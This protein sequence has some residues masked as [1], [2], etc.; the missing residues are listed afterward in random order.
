MSRII[1]DTLVNSIVFNQTF[2]TDIMFKTFNFSEDSSI[3]S[4][5]IFAMKLMINI[6][7]GLDAYSWTVFLTGLPPSVSKNPVC[8]PDI[9][10]DKLVIL[11]MR[12]YNL[13]LTMVNS[14]L[15]SRLGLT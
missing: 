11:K 15:K 10:H 12:C 6:Y 1:F 13:S 14:K 5:K 2:L 9:H 8:N 4:G 3:F 7:K